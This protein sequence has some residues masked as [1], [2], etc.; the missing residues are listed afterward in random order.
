MNILEHLTSALRSAAVFNPEIEVAPACILWTDR[1]HQ[2]EAIVP[3]LQKELPELLVHGDFAAEKRSG[4]SIWLRCVI[5]G[6]IDDVKLPSDH[7]PI[8]YLPG[9]SRQD[10]RAVEECPDPLKPLA[11]LQYRG[12]IWSQLN[13]KDWTVLAFLK[14]D[15]GG[16]GLD[17]AKD[18]DAKSAMQLALHRLLDEEIELLR[19][20]R[21]EKDYF[22]TLLTGGDPTRDLLQWLNQGDTFREAHGANEWKAFVEVCKSQFAFNPETDGILAGAE[23]LATHDGPWKPVWLRFCEAPARYQTIPE[24]I[25][26]CKMPMPTLFSGPETHGSWPQWNQDQEDSLR[27][28]LMALGQVPPHKARERILSLEKAHGSRRELVWA[29]IGDASLARAMEH[30]ASLAE[31]T[32]N[33]LAAG[34]A[35]DLSAGYSTFGWLA[36]NA[37]IRA[38]ACIERHEDYEAVTVAIRAL[39]LP[40]MEASAKHLQKEVDGSS[41]PGGTI[42][43]RIADSWKDGECILFVDGLRFDLAQ[44]LAGLL[45]S[46]GFVI[47]KKQTW[48]ALPSVTATGKAAVTPVYT[49]ISG[50]DANADFEP[51]VQETGKS[52]KGGY[53]L[54]KL[55]EKEGWQLLDHSESG[56]GKGNAWSEIGDIDHEGHQRGWKLAKNIDSMLKE[57]VERIQQLLGGGWQVIRVVTDHGWLLLPGGLPKVDL[58]SALTENKW[59]RCA[60]IKQG[61]ATDERLFPWYWNPGQ[62]FALADGVSCYRKGEEYAHGGLSLQECVIQEL[63]VSA[64]SIFTQAGSIDFTDIAWKGLRCTIAV[65]GEFTGLSFDIR[66]QPGNPDSSV[67]VSTKPLKSHGTASVV[68]EDEDLEGNDATLV[69]IDSKGGL[70]AQTGTKIGGDN[71]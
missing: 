21:L 44:H 27:Q 29:E 1:D 6:K 35:K 16:L 28:S 34:T 9:V 22:N 54:K 30:L 11:E 25:R 12:V 2:W 23:K 66:T 65:E 18:N 13:A 42:D 52:L 49:K 36:D 17:V 56:N 51:Q 57:V 32:T 47:E 63:R 59:G 33:D 48:A 43:N 4:P 5:A 26:K 70:V 68:V 38:L 39:Y 55:L 40:W 53:H 50:A 3:R 45:E 8:I 24:Q 19:G 41:Y 69:L 58:P 37:V 14:S 62:F 60:A 61:A 67:V 46:N 31:T 64:G 20:K 10:L 7:V 15:Q 71:S